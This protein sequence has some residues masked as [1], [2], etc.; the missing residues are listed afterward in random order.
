MRHQSDPPAAAL[1]NEA[2]QGSIPLAEAITNQSTIGVE[3]PEFLQLRDQMIADGFGPADIVF[4]P[5]LFDPEISETY[6]PYSDA[7]L[8]AEAPDVVAE[9]Q[10]PVSE[11]FKT[12]DE[13]VI[14]TKMREHIAGV[15]AAKEKAADADRS[16]AKANK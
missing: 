2:R 3:K 5:D 1:V 6:A 16:A 11:I 12:S 10:R 13:A 4:G 7:L 14:Q 9:G 8:D 15:L